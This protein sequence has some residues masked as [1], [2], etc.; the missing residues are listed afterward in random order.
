M[1]YSI[2]AITKKGSKMKKNFKIMI[3]FCIVVLSLVLTSIALAGKPIPPPLPTSHSEY[4]YLRFR[5]GDQ[6][7]IR[8]DGKGAYFDRSIGGE[9]K[10]EI[11]VWDLDGSFRWL[12]SYPAKMY[13]DYPEFLPSSRRINFH[14][15]VTQLSSLSDNAVLD[16]LRWYKTGTSSTER[17]ITPIT[18]PGY[19]DDNSLHVPIVVNCNYGFYSGDDFIQFAVDPLGDINKPGTDPKAITQTAVNGY[20]SGDRNITYWYTA[21]ENGI[22]YIIYSIELGNDGFE[23]LPFESGINKDGKLV[24]VTWIIRTKARTSD[25]PARLCVMKNSYSG[26]KVYLA[27]YSSFSFE[28]AVSLNRLD[29]YPSGSS[30]PPKNSNVSTTWGEI[31]GK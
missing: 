21:D 9:D 23:V 11:N 30:A 4:G 24:P 15:D 25:D 7:A 22:Q 13:Q 16:I 2:N 12:E 17:S 5:D 29:S 18:H 31:K 26:K 10:V 28:F 3:I 20:Y 8:S 27:S 6:D 1:S 14:F 19:I